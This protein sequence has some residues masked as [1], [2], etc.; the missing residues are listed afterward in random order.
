MKDHMSVT[1]AALILLQRLDAR[2]P[3]ARGSSGHTHRQFISTFMFGN[4]V[5]CDD[6]YWNTSWSIEVQGMFTLREINQ[7]KREMGSYLEWELT[8]DNPILIL[9]ADNSEACQRLSPHPHLHQFL[10]QTRVVLSHH[11]SNVNCFPRNLAT[12]VTE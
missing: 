7:M 2:F 8:V 3:T 12:I 1:F 5:T 9:I 4:K 6:T 10:H 11:S